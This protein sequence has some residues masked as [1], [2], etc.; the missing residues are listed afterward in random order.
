[1]VHVRR[2][3]VGTAAKKQILGHESDTII[4]IQFSDESVMTDK[5]AVVLSLL[6][7]LE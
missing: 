2:Y 5:L 4:S 6:H 7:N 3:A 1:M